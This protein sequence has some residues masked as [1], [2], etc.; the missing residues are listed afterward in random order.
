[1]YG[2]VCVPLDTPTVLY[3]HH[4]VATSGAGHPIPSAKCVLVNLNLYSDVSYATVQAHAP[5]NVMYVYVRLRHSEVWLP[6]PFSTL[7]SIYQN[8]S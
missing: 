7:P 4:H 6:L 3:L 1:M 8:S 2:I 5:A